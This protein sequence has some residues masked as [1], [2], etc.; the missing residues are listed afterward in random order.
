MN[1]KTGFLQHG[2]VMVNYKCNA[3]CRHCLYACS[4]ERDSGYVNSE[5]AQEICRLL[6]KGRCRSVHIGGGEP[7]LDFEGLIMMI[8]ALNQK[9]IAIDYIE[10]NAFWSADSKNALD[11]I[12]HLLA[13][14]IDTLCISVDP[15]HAEYVPYGAALTLAQLCEKT[16]M[17]YFLWRNKFISVLSR[18]DSKKTHSRSDME[19][20]LGRDY[21]N[22]TARQ[23]GISFG[24][25]AVNIEREYNTLFP[26]ENFTCDDSPCRN[27]LSTGHFH[28]DMNAFFIPPGCTGLRFPLSEAIDGIT[29][30]KFPVFDALFNGGVS[31]LFKL[32]IKHGF[33]PN[34]AGYPS[35]CNLCF[36]IRN[37]LSDKNFLELDENHYTQSLKFY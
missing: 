1:K 19:K 30:G 9:R 37:F 24:G 3:A 36:D 20:V 2:G 12:K 21:L 16:G 6:D 35:K 7:F 5:T 32:S 28:V 8:Q 11:K 14:G 15:F 27:L 25:R 17:R 18:F 26:A 4:P 34:N 29:E 13:E 31:T 23:Y 22:K 33:S 10:T